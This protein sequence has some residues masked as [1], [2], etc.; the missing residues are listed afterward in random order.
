MLLRRALWAH[1]KATFP[2]FADELGVYL[3]WG[4]FKT[5]YGILENGDKIGGFEQPEEDEEEE[6]RSQ[7]KS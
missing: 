5:I 1:L 4:V 2:A 3:T 6:E 7:A